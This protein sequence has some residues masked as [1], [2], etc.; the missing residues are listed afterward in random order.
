[1][2]HKYYIQMYVFTFCWFSRLQNC[3]LLR[4]FNFVFVI[5]PK[6]VVSQ[7]H[8]TYLLHIQI[9]MKVSGLKVSAKCSLIM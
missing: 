1:M 5:L 8:L 3:V 7:F 9:R 6:V 4:L 2:L